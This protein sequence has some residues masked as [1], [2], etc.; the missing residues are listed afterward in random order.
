MGQPDNRLTSAIATTI[1][2]FAKEAAQHASF[3]E[4]TSDVSRRIPV[5]SPDELRQL[6]E[7]IVNDSVR[8]ER[9][10]KTAEARI[11]WQQQALVTIDGRLAQLE[12]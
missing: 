4:I 9:L 5:A 12:A 7:F 2:E 6:R 8:I 10:R 1:A 3:L 11:V